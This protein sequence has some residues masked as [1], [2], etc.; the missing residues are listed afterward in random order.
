MTDPPSLPKWVR[1]L[2]THNPFYLLGTLLILIGLGMCAGEPRVV[3]SGLL[4]GLMAGYTLLL[5]GIAI[6]VI[7][8]GQVWDDARTILLLIVLMFF[9][10]S[11]SVDYHLMTWPAAGSV[12]ALAALVFVVGLSEGL[13]RVLRINL[14]PCYRGPFYLM[15]TLL[16]VYPAVPAWLVKLYLSPLVPWAMFA[17]PALVALVL[18]TLLPAA[19]MR[20]RREP[21]SNTP[22]RW[23]FY[24]WS[25]FVFL[26]VG[27][28]LRGWWLTISFEPLGGTD[29]Y[30]RPY[31]L[32]P[33]V[34]AWSALVLEMGKTRRSHGA[35]LA[36]MLLPLA[37]L[38]AAFIAPA[39]GKVET[40]FLDRLATMIGSPPQIAIAG[41]LVFYGW[42]WLR[43]VKAAEGMLAGLGLLA[44]LVGRDTLS[45][46]TLAA[47]QPIPLACV[48]AGLLLLAA[49]KRSSWRAIAG[50]A[51]VVAGIG[52]LRTEAVDGDVLWFW[53]CHGA[54]LGLLLVALVFDDPLARLLRD[55]AWRATPWLALTAAATYSWLLP[56][57]HAVV[58]SYLLLLL[59]ASIALWQRNKEL[60]ALL[61]SFTTCAANGLM[62]LSLVYGALEHSL[63]SAGLPW[64]AG[65]AVAVALALTV[66]LLKMGAWQRAQEWLEQ[67]NVALG[68]TEKAT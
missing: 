37:A 67:L 20:P 47:P 49:H 7:R 55:L 3:S 30:F 56:V 24:P 42:A 48:A 41:L 10:L 51:M 31:F 53:Q 28:A 54:V 38:A 6:L 35:V 61:A 57:S 45:L 18:L 34:L 44:S 23:P 21:A 19:R 2:Y 4:M 50:G 11:T 36:G 59:L 27:A 33:I 8:C 26:T 68:G 1:H 62:H 5:A 43:N 58:S 64:L 32:L 16:F 14:A 65:G 40:A 60:P 46:E 22:W 29:S 52:V 15:L 9:M 66:S 39:G 12:L 17:F 25:L 63:L 13:L